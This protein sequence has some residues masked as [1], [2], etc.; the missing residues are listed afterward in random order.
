MFIFIEKFNRFL[1][2]IKICDDKS[3]ENSKGEFDTV[4]AESTSEAPLETTEP[5]LD[6]SPS[7]RRRKRAT[8]ND[9]YHELE[10]LVSI[11]LPYES[12]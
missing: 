6:L 12:K 9:E 8:P 11:R 4:T 1:I 2:F 5:P 3:E 10:T 7:L